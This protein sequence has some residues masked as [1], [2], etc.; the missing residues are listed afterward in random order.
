MS[1]YLH[2]R[3]GDDVSNPTRGDM[4]KALAELDADDDEH[5]D[6][7]VTD[8]ESSWTLSAFGS[9][10]VIWERITD[11]ER[12]PRHMRGISRQQVMGLWEALAAGRIADVEAQP[13]RPGYGQES[14][15]NKVE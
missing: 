10:L 12:R 6:C 7:W 14:E 8:D 5:P 11:D 3:W 9:G 13:W 1:S 4:E 2:H 15:G